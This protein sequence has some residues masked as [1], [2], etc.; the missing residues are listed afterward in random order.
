[1]NLLARA[2]ADAK[3]RAETIAKNSGSSLDKLKG[4]MG[5]FQITCK[6]SNEDYIMAALL[7]HQA[8]IKQVLTI[9]MEFAARQRSPE[10]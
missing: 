7:I 5:V 6:N 8:E 4:S 9:R 1:M 10:Q 2:S 3:L